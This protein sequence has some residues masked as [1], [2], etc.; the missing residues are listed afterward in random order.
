MISISSC[1]SSKHL[2]QLVVASSKI[3]HHI[4]VSKEN[5]YR[6]RVIDF[7]TI[8]VSVDALR[9]QFKF[10]IMNKVLLTVHL[11]EVGDLVEIAYIGDGTVLDSIGD[12]YNYLKLVIVA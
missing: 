5:Y 10:N 3:A 11:L 7:C 6:H 8:D 9:S 1:L 2:I 4:L 12:T